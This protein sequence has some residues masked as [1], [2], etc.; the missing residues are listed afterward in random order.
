MLSRR[1]CK[2]VRFNPI[3]THFN[4]KTSELFRLTRAKRLTLVAGPERIEWTHQFDCIMALQCIFGSDCPI[5]SNWCEPL[6]SK[7]L[8]HRS[9]HV[10]IPLKYSRQTSAGNSFRFDFF[11]QYRNRFSVRH[12]AC[13][14]H[15]PH[16]HFLSPFRRTIHTLE[17]RRLLF[18]VVCRCRIDLVFFFY[19]SHSLSLSP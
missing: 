10:L 8:Y 2:F 18:S 16:T 17:F 1:Q 3:K 12:A 6:I 4:V 5:P 13:N 11:S 9:H 19:I 15:R 14:C 7:K